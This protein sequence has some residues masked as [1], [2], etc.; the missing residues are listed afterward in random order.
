MDY[1][2]PP[3]K[4]LN[5]FLNNK[6]V[7]QFFSS[8][9]SVF[10]YFL[11]LLFLFQGTINAQTTLNLGDIAFTGYQSESPEK[12]SI[13][14]LKHVEVGTTISFTDHGWQEE[15]DFFV[16][17]EGI[18]TLM[19]TDTFECGDEIVIVIE[20]NF[21]AL[22][23][24]GN[25]IGSIT[26]E[27]EF[28][29]SQAGDQIFAF[30]GTLPTQAN[31][32]NFIAAI[33][34][35]G[36]WD[37][38]STG[39][40]DS[41][42]PDAFT[43]GVNSLALYPEMNVGV[44]NCEIH[45]GSPDELRAAI[46]NKLNWETSDELGLVIPP[47]CGFQCCLPPVIVCAADNYNLPDT[48]NPT[49]PPAALTFNLPDDDD[50]DPA[51]PTV[52]EG[53][54]ELTLTHVDVNSELDCIHVLKRIYTITDENG[55]TSSC[56][57]SFMWI[58]D[59][60]GPTFDNPPADMT[61]ECD[62]IPEVPEVTA[63]DNCAPPD[64]LFINEIHYDNA[65]P[66]VGEFIEIVG[67]AGIDLSQY[68]LYAYEPHDGEYD[69]DLF[70]TG[71]IPDEGN[72]W[73]AVVFDLNYLG[74]K[75]FEDGI[76]GLALVKN[77]FVI[78]F[79]SYEGIVIA[80]NG[81][82]KGCT[83]IEIGVEEGA[84]P[85]GESLQ[86]IGLEGCL[87]NN[88]TWIGPDNDIEGLAPESPGLINEGQTF[89]DE[90]CPVWPVVIT[91]EQTS[92]PGDCPQEQTIT[93]TW[94]ATDTCG[95]E[96][97]HVQ[98]IV[99]V[100]TTPP[101]APN[102]PADITVQ[103]AADVPPPLNLTAPDNC[104]AN[105]PGLPSSSTTPGSCPN[106][107]VITRT[108]TF[109]DECGNSSSV[110]HTITVHDNTAPV[111]PN[112]PANVTVQ[113]ATDVPPPV[114]LTAIDNCDGPI[115]VAPTAQITPGN[116]P[117]QF[118]MVR[119]WTFVDGC[120]N[121]SS[122]SQ[123]INVND[124]TAPVPPT[125]PGN[126]M[127]QCA[128]DVPPPVN[129]TAIDN[130]DG[131]ITVAPTTQTTPGSCANQFIVVRTWT[132][133][134]GCGNT[135]SVSQ[136]ITVHDNTPPTFTVP[137]DITIE[138]DQDPNDLTLTGNISNVMD[139]CDPN[140]TSGHTDEIDLSGCGGYTGTIIRTWTAT[141]ECGNTASMDQIITI[142]DTTPPTFT[143]PPDVT[144]DC[145]QDPNDLEITGDVE[146]EM[147]N[148]D[149]GGATPATVWINE[150]HYDNDGTDVGEFIEI[151]GTA[152]VDLSTYQLVLY[153][154]ANGAAYNT[155]ALSG[156][157]PDQS[158]GFGAVSFSYPANGIQNGSPDGMALVQ[159]GNI[160]IQ[161]LSYEGTF[162][163]VGGPANGMSSTDIGVEETGTTPIGFSLQL[164]GTGSVYN[165][166]VW[167]A[168][169][170]QS[171]GSLNTGQTMVA[172]P[173]PMGLLV[174]YF[175][176][177]TPICNGVLN[178]ITR[179]WRVTDACGNVAEQTQ[180]ITVVDNE[181]P[182]FTVP[183][184]VTIEC[185]DDPDDL[186]ITGNVTNVE[187]NCDPNPVASYT[188]VENLTGCGGY[189][190]T[191]TRTWTVTDGCGNATSQTQ[192]ITV[193]DTTPPTFTTPA[194]VT[195]ECEDDPND[196]D[197]TGNVT[198]AMDNC[199]GVGQM[200]IW[201]NEFHY[202]NV[203]TDVNEFIE[204]AGTAG[205]NLSTYQ[206]ILYNG[207]NGLS[208][209]T[210]NLTGIIPNQ[211]NGFGTIAFVYPVNGIQNGSPD[212]IALVKD[213]TNV[214]EFI[215]YLGIFTAT[216]GPANGMLSVNVGVSENAS[217][218]V[219]FSLQKIGSGSAGSA[220]TWSGP[221][222]DSPGTLN[223]GQTMIAVP[224]PSSMLTIEYEDE[225]DVTVC[226]G[227]TILR[228]WTVTD[229]CDNSTSQVQTITVNPPNIPEITCPADITVECIEDA[230]I[231]P[232]NATVVVYCDLE[233][234]LWVTNP[235]IEG[236]QNCPGTTYTF[237]YKVLD[238]CGGYADCQQVV[239][240][241]NDPPVITV[242]PG[243]TV[244]CYSDIVTSPSDA[245]VTTSCG[246]E[247]E[248]KILPPIIEG[249]FDCPGTT[250]TYPYR[251]RDNCGREVIANRVFTIGNNAPPTIVAPADQTV[252]CF[253]NFNVNPNYAIVT[254]G[255]SL[256]YVTTV[257]G[258]VISGEDDCPGTTYTYTYT[259]TD[260]CGRT[261]SDNRVFTIQNGPPVMTCPENCL[262][263]NCE[264]GD[265]LQIIEAWIATVTATSSCGE[266][267]VVTNNYNPNNLG[268]CIWNG[269]TPVTFTATDDCG[270]TTTCVGEI[271]ITD[272]EP[273]I[274]IEP[275][276]DMLALCNAITQSVLDQW[277]DN[278]GGAVIEDG[279]WGDDITWSTDPANPT[280]NC[281][282]MMGNT[283][284][285][286]T[287][288]AT[289]GC[290]N[291][292]STTAT[293]TAIMM[294]GNDII[295]HGGLIT[296]EGFGVEAVEVMLD[297]NAPGM[298]SMLMSG[299]DGD[300]QFDDLTVGNNYVVVPEKNDDPLNGL[301]TYD[302]VL[303]TKHILVTELLNSPYKIIAADVNNSGTVTTLDIVKLRRL[304]LFID[305]T[306]ENNTSWRFVD[307]EFV[308]PDPSN[309]FATSFP[310]VFSVN[311]LLQSEE[312][313]FVAIKVGDLNGSA[314]P[315]SLISGENRNIIGNLTFELEDQLLTA[316]NQFE[317]QFRSSDFNEMLGYQ[318][319]LNF[320]PDVMEFIETET[321]NLV[322]LGA[323]NFG[324]TLLEKGVITTSWSNNVATNMT[325]DEILFTLRFTAKSDARLSEVMRISSQY[326]RSEAYNATGL[327]NIALNFNL[328]DKAQNTRFA[329]YQ[330]Q[331]NPF[332][333]ETVIGFNL[334]ESGTARMKFF[335][336]TGKLLKVVEGEF[337]QGY[338]EISVTSADFPLEGLFIY[339][340]LEA[341]YYTDTKKMILMTLK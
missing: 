213:G 113:C 339:Y 189:T 12:F 336:I 302:I 45:L 96:T 37:E 65:G 204:I 243:E 56:T 144:I 138:C 31:Q 19:L 97:V 158:N 203:G 29:L 284:I 305:S 73:G 57:Q 93:R 78:E 256:G 205:I 195:I 157:V 67:M 165:D 33:Q 66:D 68:R 310:E 208:Y 34:M 133:V 8:G 239:T 140:P 55:K 91:F 17:E 332:K 317:I 40:H 184:N 235:D 148:C 172:P 103:C 112:P 10:R 230:G 1:F 263:Q 4:S 105:A 159:G 277:V 248:L 285:D 51:R 311:G 222:D 322:K 211:S 190:G 98:T 95:F 28:T 329:L 178:N 199:T 313:N 301:S 72:G 87:S 304:I 83:S 151:A 227:G 280:I 114:N 279:C 298:P 48:C 39:T 123:T 155:L 147:D 281:M 234:K 84:T 90:Q 14:F 81:P 306:F 273:P 319:T 217:T 160:V 340:Q 251:V 53:C 333:N 110:S 26:E 75:Y 119:T 225:S 100:D 179:L 128:D 120:G 325:G 115:T 288:T 296:E 42:K 153:N 22:D 323:D 117:N 318:F 9:F 265:Y 125:P 229:A 11:L 187:D 219:G 130:C 175:D 76:S 139:N 177:F 142:V 299:V 188:D 238:D 308:F 338:N 69:D 108:Y 268:F 107:F 272:T 13:V 220:F 181:A 191:I 326:T 129:L 166:F 89:D 116:C 62:A 297:G 168:P 237:T 258:P 86:R 209:N 92:T 35:N 85:I 18:I 278:H 275:A 176:S 6:N 143:A 63:T 3:K 328:G 228:T 126:V 269:M 49:A 44:Y 334:P 261:A 260:D 101:D 152:G 30:Q 134:D 58:V 79:I 41:A 252:E 27:G 215:S 290:G 38:D 127:V 291:S 247:Y 282:G 221:A 337:K 71:I 341:G 61:V 223:V 201:I 135:S 240:I 257:S 46:N 245:T 121:T 224:P 104:G 169:A 167:N 2:Y 316:G 307:A 70:L 274:I 254:T 335:D 94:T 52:Y 170:P 210:L 173:P 327:L 32:S 321:G 180:M 149:T 60:E 145:T 36:E 196:L 193:V 330:N 295:I 141:D 216:N 163:A 154:G 293:F 106:Q 198:D 186:T 20:P 303:M 25:V 266:N 74:S 47:D 50:P 185:S 270:R 183:A 150:F 312:A 202:D 294:G 212:G 118:V 246:N 136:T 276:Q 59:D 182:T 324:L 309:P 43:D 64:I 292:V 23:L 82:A 262:I 77:G 233:Y 253:Y 192:I 226:E 315:S 255:C 283:S 156:I 207:A 241:E 132:F 7:R 122:V 218:P 21:L 194:D 146:D 200:D 331:P 162:V 289:D 109:T 161:F 259:V 249:V 267:I 174:E 137:D 236:A 271:V 16:Y 5:G 88:F 164:T 320:N 314:D 80:T 131:P 15:G 197:L 242:I 287:F 102:A 214:I 250:V 244:L 232:T 111:P 54:G 124:T 99:V 300:Y 286:V 24:E 171:P 206:L 264:D 231:D